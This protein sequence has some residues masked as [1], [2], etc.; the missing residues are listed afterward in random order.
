MRVAIG[1][2]L[3]E[4]N[5]FN[6]RLTGLAD[7]RL[8]REDEVIRWWGE[9]HHEMGGFIEGAARNG[10]ELYPTLMASATPSGPVAAEAFGLLAGELEERLTNAPALD[11]LLLALHGAL[12]S[13]HHPD[14]DGE[15][16]RRLRSLLGS[17]FPIVVTHDLHANVSDRVVDESTALVIY[18]T[19]PHVDQRQRGLQAARII[20]RLIR[21]E[22]QI[23]QALSKPP[24]LLN[25]VRQNTNVEPVLDIM[26]AARE[27]EKQPEVL[28]ANV[29]LGYQYADVFEM[30][31][32]AVV[33]TDGD[34]ELA[35]REAQRLADLIW[36][37]RDQLTIDL[38][39]AAAAVRQ[40]KESQQTPVVLVDMGDNI[41]AGSAGDSTFILQ[42]LLRQEAAGWVVVLADPEAVRQCESAGVGS[43]LTMR[44]GG[45]QDDLHGKLV[46]V[47]GHVRCLHDGKF[48]ETEPRHGGQRYYDQGLT[49]VLE[50]GDLNAESPRLVVL[51]SARQV[52][53]S[54]HQLLSLGIQP[55]RQKILVVKAAIAFRA[56]YEPIAGQI[57]EVDTPGLTAVNPAHFTY[58]QVRRPLWGVEIG[59]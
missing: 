39:G 47:T 8:Q 26:Q 38:P 55:Q 18:K 48:V 43:R 2:I 29:A 27:L 59:D 41:G 6:P 37:T 13:E 4:S 45:K 7:F 23:A 25:I 52:P 40:A 36:D 5:T 51:T 17:D 57:I 16:V 15:I 54:L 33:V 35:R 46:E 28:A 44:V 12:V 21:G 30:G 10:Y 58:R 53:F 9:A 49:A 19:Y 14:G 24:L 22:I 31:P 32:A 20:A 1:G 50:I 34:L 3:H 56:A 42:E 11:G